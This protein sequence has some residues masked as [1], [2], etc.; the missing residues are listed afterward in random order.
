MK[1]DDMM[2]STA[3]MTSTKMMYLQLF[4]FVM[5]DE[6]FFVINVMI[7]RLLSHSIRKSVSFMFYVFD[8]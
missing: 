8:D 2:S 1:N 4:E 5:R 3:L 7:T 6:S